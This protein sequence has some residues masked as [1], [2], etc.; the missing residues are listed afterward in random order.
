MLLAGGDLIES[1]KIPKLWLD[2]DVRMM[3]NR[4]ICALFNYR[5]V[6]SFEHI[7]IRTLASSHFR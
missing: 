7:I 5:K 1:F 6:Y 4:L 3:N 2:D